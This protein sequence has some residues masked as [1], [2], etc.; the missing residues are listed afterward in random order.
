MRLGR[1]NS[2]LALAALTSFVAV[3]TAAE[4]LRPEPGR[5]TSIARRSVRAESLSDAERERLLSGD[6][7]SRPMAFGRGEGRYVGG[8]SYQVVRASPAEVL[9]AFGDVGELPRMLPRTKAARLVDVTRRG[10]RVELTQ[11]TRLVDTT[12]TVLLRRAGA[13]QLS[14][15]LD[16]SRPHGIRDVWGWLRA[17]PLGEGR[18]LVTVAVA[19]DVGPGLVRTLFEDRIQR[20]ILSTPRHIRDYLEPRALARA[21]AAVEPSRL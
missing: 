11:G 10:A 3:D 1:W 8:V 12:Y 9:A 6:V 18:T 16:P 13:S 5:T 21:R 19:L 17:R 14:F 20:V 15:R 2:A 7:V 4:P